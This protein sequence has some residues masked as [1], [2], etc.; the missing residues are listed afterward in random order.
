MGPA[1]SALYRWWLAF[2]PRPSGIRQSKFLSVL[3][4]TPG[5]RILEVG[6][7][8]GYYSLPVARMI[9]PTGH[10]TI[11]DVDQG[12]LDFTLARLRKHGLDTIADAVRCDVARLPFADGSFE[13]AF[14]VA[15]LGE[16]RDRQAALSELFRV[17]VPGGRLVVGE[18][19]FDPHAVHADDLQRLAGGAGFTDDGQVGGRSGW[20]I[21]FRRPDKG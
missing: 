20:F 10:L 18:T 16:V 1:Q 19:T 13:A 15:V 17:L 11:V 14:M 12:M 5:E 8:G 3:N 4:P 7:G 9:G 21:R 2:G 6:P